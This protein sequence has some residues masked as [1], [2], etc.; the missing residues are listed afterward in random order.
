[1]ISS[2]Y[3]LGI[4]QA[5][6][7]SHL[8]YRK[9]IAA[10]CR[11][12]KQ[13]NKKTKTRNALR[14]VVSPTIA[15]CNL[16]QPLTARTHDSILNTDSDPE[17]DYFVDSNMDDIVTLQQAMS[18]VTCELRTSGCDLSFPIPPNWTARKS[19]HPQFESKLHAK[20]RVDEA[21][22]GGVYERL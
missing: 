7:H 15:E 14:P 10:A 2:T 16:V 17:Q 4:L 12:S 20:P 5:N 19:T 9:R 1:M 8:S 11:P 3:F 18:K 22:L 21:A 6:R 13:T